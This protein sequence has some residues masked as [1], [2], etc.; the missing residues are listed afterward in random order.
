MATFGD[1][2]AGGDTFPA[3]SDRAI[4]SKFTAPEAGTVTQINARFDATSGAD[5]FKG[6]IYAADGAGGIP[7]TRLGVGNS[8]AVPGGG[9]DIASDGL[10]VAISAA[11]DYWIG[12]VGQGIALV[13]QCDVSGGLSRME[14][15]TYAAPAATWTESGTGAGQV[16]AYATYTAGPP[17]PEVTPLRVLSSGLRF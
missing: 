11:T 14:G 2:T 10:S 8:A 7:G 1:T 13:W 15:T 17:P 16:N 3:S 6:L 9:G 5:N 4:L 12:G